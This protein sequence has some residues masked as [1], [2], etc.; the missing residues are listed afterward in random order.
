MRADRIKG[1]D[2]ATG[3]VLPVLLIQQLS[4]GLKSPLDPFVRIDFNIIGD[5]SVAVFLFLT[6]ITTGL[7]GVMPGSLNKL[8]KNLLITGLILA[9]A[10]LAVSAVW[11]TG[12]VL[13]VGLFLLFSAVLVVLPTGILYVIAIAPV[14]FYLYQ[15][16]GLYTEVIVNP[17]QQL[18]PKSIV[19]NLYKDAYFGLVPW[20]F[21]FIYGMIHSRGNFLSRT[22]GQLRIAIGIGL[23]LAAFGTEYALEQMLQGNRLP[24]DHGFIRNTFLHLQLPAFLLSSIGLCL[25]S[26]HVS[27]SVNER[28]SRAA[29][30]RIIRRYGR[31][32]YSV[33][34]LHLL[35]LITL[36]MLRKAG[37]TFSSDLV[38]LGISMIASAAFAA[39][40]W[41]WTKNHEL[42]PVEQLSLN[43]SG[44]K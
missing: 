6:G 20:F 34:F 24:Y 42:G 30:S 27:A 31:A 44:R 13:V 43:F 2:L 9:L 4:L 15:T 5:G 29:W 10:G 28:A 16:L 1:I 18:Q 7:P 21:F 12:L 11:S 38:L 22:L 26:L 19:M 8:R 3:L 25:I 23:I 37:S 17:L 14:L 35:L 36:V 39:F 40:I 33:L 32:R 41:Y